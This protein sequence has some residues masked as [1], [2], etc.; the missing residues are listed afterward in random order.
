MSMAMFVAG[1]V[2]GA[3]ACSVKQP[4]MVAGQG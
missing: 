4:L 3:V 1:A 2:L